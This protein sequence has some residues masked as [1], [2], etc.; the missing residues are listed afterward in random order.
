MEMRDIHLLV[1]YIRMML[2]TL[3]LNHLFL[4]SVVVGMNPF[5]GDFFSFFFFF[6]FF[7]WGGGGGASLKQ[8]YLL[9]GTE[10]PRIWHIY[11]V[12]KRQMHQWSTKG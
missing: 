8:H 2:T 6:F 11:S 10:N 5:H 9:K 12:L 7:F 1:R 4:N 3:E